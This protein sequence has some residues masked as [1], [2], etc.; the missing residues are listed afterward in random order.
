MIAYG[1][2]FRAAQFAKAISL[3]GVAASPLLL[4]AL[5]HG[6][7]AAFEFSARAKEVC[8]ELSER[9]PIAEITLKELAGSRDAAGEVWLDL[10]SPSGEMPAGELACLCALARLRQ[11]QCV[12]EIGTARGWTTRHLARNT[13]KDCRIFTVDLPAEGRAAAAASHWSDPHL[14]TAAWDNQRDFEAEPKITQILH[15]STTIEWENLLDRKVD[16]ALI[17][18]SHLYEHVRADTER[19]RRVLAPTAIVL[20][21]DYST[22]EVRRGVRKYLLELHSSGWPIRRLAGTHFGVYG[23]ACV[24]DSKESSKKRN[25]HDRPWPEIDEPEELS[26][27]CLH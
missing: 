8:D 10:G 23:L 11:P 27:R 14:V 12:V 20:W 19:L 3:V 13:P 24:G 9:D 22:V 1:R 16:L 7:Q 17:D 18:G 5:R 21:H 15:D 25:N 6:P 2:H 26:E 4:K